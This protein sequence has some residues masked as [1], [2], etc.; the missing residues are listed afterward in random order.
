MTSA[1]RALRGATAAP[2]AG[3]A[4]GVGAARG[5]CTHAAEAA[6]VLPKPVGRGSVRSSCP[7]REGQFELA[8]WNANGVQPRVANN[9]ALSRKLTAAG[10]GGRW[11]RFRRRCCRGQHFEGWLRGLATGGG[12]VGGVRAA[13]GVSATQPQVTVTWRALAEVYSGGQSIW[14]SVIWCTVPPLGD[15][16]VTAKRT[17]EVTQ[18]FLAIGRLLWTA[19]EIEPHADAG[20][21]A[22][23]AAI[24]AACRRGT[25]I[26][27][28]C[29]RCQAGAPVNM[30]IPQRAAGKRCPALAGLVPPPA[31]DGRSTVLLAARGRTSRHHPP[32]EIAT[33]L[34][35]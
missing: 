29:R 26:R 10:A 7:G 16:A 4:S 32:P 12:P 1:A 3:S 19:P 21:S 28:G 23:V 11:Q 25:A 6:Q 5:R 9:N 22:S 34:G 27:L 13:S 31:G 15:L 24:A 30:P 17:A 18:R 33:V 20:S 35:V 8:R 14:S 2:S